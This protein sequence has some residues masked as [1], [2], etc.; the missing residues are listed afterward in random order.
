MGEHKTT[1]KT[2]HPRAYNYHLDLHWLEGRRAELSLGEGKPTLIVGAPIEFKGEP[3][4][5]SAEDL[6]VS[7]IAVCQMGAFIAFA[8]RKGLEFTS[9]TDSAVGLMVV[10]DRKLR[11]TGVT[12][13]PAITITREEDRETALKIVEDAHHMCPVGNAVNFPV[14]VEPEIVVG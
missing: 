5:I 3:G 2:G 6:L 14:T 12:L 13:R 7:A 1:E 4:N 11:F 10:V 9:Y 8:T